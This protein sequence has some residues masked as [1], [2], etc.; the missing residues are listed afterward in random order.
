MAV[1]IAVFAAG[2]STLSISLPAVTDAPTDYRSAGK[3][4]W[5]DL[6]TTDIEASRAFYA[7]LFGWE[8]EEVPLSFGLGRS[9]KYLLIRNKGRLVGGMV[10]TSRLGSDVNNSQWISIMSVADVE[11]AAEQ[12]KAAGGE[13][14]TPPTDLD[15][16]GK[17]AVVKDNTGAL[18]AIL[19]TR[20]GDP[21]DTAPGPGDFMW[22]ELWTD[23]IAAAAE[24]YQALAPFEP[25]SRETSKGLYQGL[26]INGAPRFGMLQDPVE[27]LD[28][29]WAPY[30]KVADMSLLARV[31]ELGGKVALSAEPRALGG[32]VALI[33]GP[34]GAGVA[35]QTRPEESR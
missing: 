26:A 13:V 5:H 12:V 22:D 21:I 16:R 34:S 24:F 1:L 25:V 31:A 6:L 23:D 17:I 2:C 30:I 18:F 14:K 35:L 20:S 15:Q 10:D 9:S 27:D 32:E 3:I 4:I 33:L 8:F 29:T 28:P 7:G 11:L 19:E